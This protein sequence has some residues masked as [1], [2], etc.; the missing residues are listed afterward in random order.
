MLPSEPVT[1]VAVCVSTM[2]SYSFEEV[3]SGYGVDLTQKNLRL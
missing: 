3:T 2:H 1:G